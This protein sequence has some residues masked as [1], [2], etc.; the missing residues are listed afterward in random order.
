MSAAAWAAGA[1]VKG[2]DRVGLQFRGSGPLAEVYADADGEGNVR[3]YVSNPLVDASPHEWQDVGKALG[4]GVLNVTTDMKMRHQYRSVVPL[5]KGDVTGDVEY[6]FQT[7]VQIPSVMDLG[8][9]LHDDGTVAVSGGYLLQ[10]LPG[11]AKNALAELEGNLF[12]LPPLRTLMAD[13][14]GL[15]RLLE[16]VF[17]G[18]AFTA[19]AAPLRFHCPCSRSR[20]ERTLIALGAEELQDMLEKEQGAE[21]RCEF[22]CEH[23]SFLADDLR[24]IIGKARG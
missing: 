19:T 6:Y 3:G 11:A 18:Y 22:C 8:T 14:E 4:A 24:E 23:Y 10:A 1:V 20:V 15:H 17:M 12:G 16:R 13:E 2:K 7:S 9:W 5:L 21:V